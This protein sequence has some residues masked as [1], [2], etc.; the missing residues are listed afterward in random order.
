[1]NRYE[2]PLG[3]E[4][5]AAG[6]G[7][8]RAR[9]CDRLETM[10]QGLQE[11]IEEQRHGSERGVDPRLQQLQIQVVKIQAQ[12]LKLTGPMLPEPPPEADP[13]QK[14]LD[15]AALAAARMEEVV[16]RLAA[17]EAGPVRP[18]PAPDPGGIEA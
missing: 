16:D 3:A 15:A 5:L 8:E 11:D 9:L 18:K 7:F 2:K 17:D 14:L 4:E 10:W 1:V 6:A 13:Q 12:L